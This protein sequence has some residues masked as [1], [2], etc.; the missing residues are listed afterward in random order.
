MT[1][2]CWW[3]TEGMTKKE[4]TEKYVGSRG[5]VRKEKDRYTHIYKL[6]PIDRFTHIQT[7][8]ERERERETHTHTHKHTHTHIYTHIY[9]YTLITKIIKLYIY[10]YM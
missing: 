7:Q 3:G 1:H 4:W 5:N 10:I 6:K 2:S 9:I 8:R